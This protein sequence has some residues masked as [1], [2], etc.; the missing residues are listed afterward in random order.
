MIEAQNILVEMRLH[1]YPNM[2]R[3]E[4]TKWYKEVRRMAYFKQKSAEV[5]TTEELGRFLRA[6][7]GNG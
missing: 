1:D 5:M 2:K 7:V 4:R 3:S 6:K